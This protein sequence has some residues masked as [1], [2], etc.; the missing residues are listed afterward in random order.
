MVRANKRPISAIPPRTW[1]YGRFL[2]FGSAAVIGAVDGAGKGLLAVVKAIAMI[3]GK[4][5]LGEK[6][7]RTG[8]VAIVTYEDDQDEWE[9]RFAA[10]CVRYELDYETVIQSVYFLHKPGGR[11]TLAERNRDGG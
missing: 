11:V 6:V 5:L 3:T 4:P 9:R 2:L 7:W 10:A 1:A 8:P